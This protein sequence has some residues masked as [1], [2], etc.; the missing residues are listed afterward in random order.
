MLPAKLTL[1]KL[2][3]CHAQTINL[4]LQVVRIASWTT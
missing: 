2:C 4:G 1:F 3:I